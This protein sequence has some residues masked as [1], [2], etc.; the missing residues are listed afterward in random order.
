MCD[1]LNVSLMS[2]VPENAVTRNTAHCGFEPCL[3]PRRYS[4]FASAP[5]IVQVPLALTSNTAPSPP[6]LVYSTGLQAPPVRIGL[7]TVGHAPSSESSA[8][9]PP[10]KSSLFG[11]MV[12]CPQTHALAGVTV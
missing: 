12:P 4:V 7:A 11:E 1:K 10:R 2:Q 3:R 6:E 5:V 8:G 9:Q